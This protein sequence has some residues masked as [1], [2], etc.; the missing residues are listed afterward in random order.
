MGSFVFMAAFR[1][2]AERV[3]NQNDPIIRLMLL[4]KKWDHCYYGAHVLKG[5]RGKYLS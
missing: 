3:A 4:T 2:S 5:S 1:S